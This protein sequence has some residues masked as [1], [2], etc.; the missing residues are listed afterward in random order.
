M[1][2][3]IE[4]TSAPISSTFPTMSPTTE[5]PYPSSWIRFDVLFFLLFVTFTFRSWLAK[6]DREAI[7]NNAHNYNGNNV[8]HNENS[9]DNNENSIQKLSTQDWIQLYNKTFDSNGN[10]ITLTSEHIV[11][12]S[13]E[14]QGK[15]DDVYDVFDDI[16]LGGYGND[17]NNNNKG[18]KLNQS[19]VH[20]SLDTSESDSFR[21]SFRRL[22]SFSNSQQSSG[23]NNKSKIS[24]TCIICF[25]DFEPGDEVVWAGGDCNNNNENNDHCKH[26]FHQECI[27][28]YLASNSHR[29]F[30]N[31]N[32]KT[33]ENPCPTCRQNFCTV[34]ED[35]LAEA[36]KNKALD[37]AMNRNDADA[38]AGAVEPTE[39]PPLPVSEGLEAS[40]ATAFNTATDQAV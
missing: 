11:R 16:E 31:K 3:N 32:E 27:A 25:E 13:K 4:P 22:S 35:D 18:N 34:S 9:D 40:P 30:K 39:T 5:L 23:N 7:E 24:G 12:T 28:Q 10:R 2:S 21:L 36:I 33:I 17:N 1:A 26:V 20:L 14:K 15:D 37:I 29:R 38:N 8:N 6:I 19:S